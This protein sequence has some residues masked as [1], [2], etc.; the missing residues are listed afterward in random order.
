MELVK[1]L[2]CLPP[3]LHVEASECLLLVEL[4]YF[5][6]ARHLV[7][8][9]VYLGEET[10]SRPIAYLEMLIDAKFRIMTHQ[11]NIVLLELF[12]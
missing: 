1:D 11:Q 9:G 5:E 2:L 6:H 8:E 10:T 4:E 7:V 3:E 12:G